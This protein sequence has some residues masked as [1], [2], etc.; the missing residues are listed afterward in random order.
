MN[1][2]SR[3]KPALENKLMLHKLGKLSGKIGGSEPNPSHAAV[4]KLESRKPVYLREIR[5]TDW[6]FE[7]G[8]NVIGQITRG[9]TCFSSAV[10]F[11]DI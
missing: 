10:R 6:M 1:F 3:H 7:H 4:K 5:E 2:N 9:P 11:R 8:E